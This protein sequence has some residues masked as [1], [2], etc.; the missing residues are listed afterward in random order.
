VRFKDGV[1]EASRFAYNTGSPTRRYAD[2]PI[3]RYADTPI[4][5]Y[6]DTP[7]RRYDA[8]RTCHAG[9]AGAQS[10]SRQRGAFCRRHGNASCGLGFG[11]QEGKED[12]AA[13]GDRSQSDETDRI[14][15]TLDDKTG[16]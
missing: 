4:R 7:I 6:A 16:E 8:L 5:R 12:E 1:G 11:H 14:T 9:R 2:T 15:E 10:L 13:N 3:R